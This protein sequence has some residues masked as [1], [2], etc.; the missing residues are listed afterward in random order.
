MGSACAQGFGRGE[1]LDVGVSKS[2]YRDNG[3]IYKEAIIQFKD[4]F[5]R[6]TNS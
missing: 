2:L 3:Q 1:E 6:Y 5:F 4:Q